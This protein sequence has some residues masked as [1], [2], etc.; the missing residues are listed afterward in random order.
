MDLKTR[1]RTGKE[2]TVLYIRPSSQE[3]REAVMRFLE[4]RG[5]TYQ[6]HMDREDVRTSFLPLAADLAQ[7]QIRRM[8][9]VTVAA[10]AAQSGI[11]MSETEFFEAMR[12]RGEI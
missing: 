7:K 11:L 6:G 3:A 5:Y 2:R 4:E 12:T 9:N 8:G 1:D 10:C